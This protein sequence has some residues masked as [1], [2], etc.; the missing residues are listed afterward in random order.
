MNVLSSMEMYCVPLT[1]DG[2]KGAGCCEHDNE[3]SGYVKCVEVLILADETS[4][5]TERCCVQFVRK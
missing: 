2:G 3:Q 1:R 4:Y 5:G